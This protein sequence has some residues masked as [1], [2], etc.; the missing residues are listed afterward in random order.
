MV[1]TN[2]NLIG[3]S[4]T[5]FKTNPPMV[6]YADGIAALPIPYQGMKFVPWI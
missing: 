2:L 6:V 3:V 1:I 5:P 4:F